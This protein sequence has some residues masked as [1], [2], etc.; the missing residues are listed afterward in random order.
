M[1]QFLLGHYYRF[2]IFLC[3]EKTTVMMARKYVHFSVFF[4]FCFKTK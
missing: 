2:V 1:P 4:G 3:H